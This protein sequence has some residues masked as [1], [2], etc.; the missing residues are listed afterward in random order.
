MNI[1]S[2]FRL[3]TK[4]TVVLKRILKIYYVKV[5][6]E[7]NWLHEF[8]SIFWNAGKIAQRIAIQNKGLFQRDSLRRNRPLRLH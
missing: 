4:T 8:N 1:S 6:Y 2:Y 7:N 3:L 5:N